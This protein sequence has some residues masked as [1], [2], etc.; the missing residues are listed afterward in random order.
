MPHLDRYGQK[1]SVGRSGLRDALAIRM[2]WRHRLS[3]SELVGLRW[4]YVAWKTVRLTVHR[5]KGSIDS[6]Y[7]LSGDELRGLRAMQ[8]TQ[9][10]GCRFIFTNEQRAP[11]TADS[12]EVAR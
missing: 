7:P 6:P 2:C 8:R 12:D 3:V 5:A 9:E 11:M 4:D 10:P 1:K